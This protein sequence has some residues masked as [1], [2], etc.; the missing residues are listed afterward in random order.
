MYKEI[1]YQVIMHASKFAK[2]G[3]SMENINSTLDD[4]AFHLETDFKSYAD[5]DDTLKSMKAS[6]REAYSAVETAYGGSK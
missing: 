2:A 5:D 4:I 6:V 3:V 1:L